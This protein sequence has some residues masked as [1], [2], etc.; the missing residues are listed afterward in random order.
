MKKKIKNSTAKKKNTAEAF[1][2]EVKRLTKGK[3]VT[4]T[5]LQKYLDQA[6]HQTS[7]SSTASPQSS[8]IITTSDAALQQ[9]KFIKGSGIWRSSYIKGRYHN[10]G[11]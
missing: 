2:R 11:E 8:K 5:N 3:R 1:F 9:H 7:N 4:T 6:V 10:S